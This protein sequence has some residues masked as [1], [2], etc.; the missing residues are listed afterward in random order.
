MDDQRRLRLVLGV[1]AGQLRAFDR[2]IAA[3]GKVATAGFSS[4][5]RVWLLGICCIAALQEP[6][7]PDLSW[8]S[9]FTGFSYA[10]SALC[11]LLLPPQR[12]ILEAQQPIKKRLKPS[13]T[14]CA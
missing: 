2:L 6:G 11:V 12:S 9:F 13:S 10:M 1:R 8:L 5:Q 3:V 7:Q 4:M 14:H